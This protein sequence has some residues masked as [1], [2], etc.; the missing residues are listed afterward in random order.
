MARE[1]GARI[2]FK[3]TSL[4]PAHET[5]RSLASRARRLYVR[6]VPVA[7]TGPPI[8][9]Y[10]RVCRDDDLPAS[11]F[12]VTAAVFREQMRYLAGA[13]YYTPRL[14]EVLTWNGGMPRTHKTP[15][16]LTFDDGYADNFENALPILQE[17]GFTAAV[18]LVLDLT[19]RFTW[20]GS[21]ASLRAPL[22][23]PRDIRTME[24]A[25]VE[26][27][28]HSVNHPS[29]TL[30]GE[31]E[32]A[33]ELARSRELLGSIVERPLPVLAYPYGEVNQR[34][35]EAVRRTGYAAALAVNSGPLAVHADL[36][37]IRRILITNRSD[38]VYMRLKLSGADKLYRWS[39][40]K[41][42]EGLGWTKRSSRGAS[43]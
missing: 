36:F 7:P 11:E 33:D 25:G 31:S 12:A 13:G 8:L 39:K 20:W 23:M 14:S 34:V 42:R 27:G 5:I 2:H 24:T 9:L 21:M 43:A 3:G 40:W 30:L 22:L 35:K 18:F 17:F 26:F 6:K 19:R 32:L 1:Q 16:V 28:S 29:L 38:A 41:V 37:E 15:V 10:H 4:S